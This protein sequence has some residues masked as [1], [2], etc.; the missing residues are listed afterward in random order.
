[1]LTLEMVGEAIRVGLERPVGSFLLAEV[2]RTIESL[3]DWRLQHGWHT[4]FIPAPQ[5]TPGT[6]LCLTTGQPQT[7]AS[8]L[9]LSSI[10]MPLLVRSICCWS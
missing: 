10:R 4:F 2:H 9:S 3:C 8:V 1:M 7:L 5:P 6:V